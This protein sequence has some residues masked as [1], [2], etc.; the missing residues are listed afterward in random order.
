MNA[1]DKMIFKGEMIEWRGPAPFYFV[2]I[3]PAES[4]KIKERA[5]QLTYGW[6]VIPVIGEIGETEF[7]TSLIPKD[8]IYLL[9]I[10]NAVRLDEGLEVHQ[11]VHVKLTLGKA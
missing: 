3:P 4:L 5:A 2:G 8:G 6:G 7:T 1:P 9:P 10:K 11:E